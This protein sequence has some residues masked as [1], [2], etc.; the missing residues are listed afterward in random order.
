MIQTRNLDAI[1]AGAMM[2]SRH[3]RPSDAGSADAYYGRPCEPNFTI[4]GTDIE[5]GEMTAAEVAEYRTAYA[6]EHDR[7]DWGREYTAADDD[8]GD[9]E[10]S[11][12][13]GE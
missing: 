10:T 5:A 13:E 6:S 2:H 3:R 8:Q 9:D 1:F 7:K 12:D 11:N 4:N